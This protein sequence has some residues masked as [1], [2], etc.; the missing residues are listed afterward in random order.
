[1]RIP[2]LLRGLILA[3]SAISP[4]SLLAQFQPLNPDEL[5]MTSDAKAPGA[6]A[7]YLDYEESDNDSLHNQNYYARIKVLTEKGK[8]AATVEL[9]AYR[10]GEFSIGSI[11]GRTIHPDGSI[12]PL[13]VK[14]DELLVVKRGEAQ[15]EKKVFTLPS[16]EVGSVLEYS[17]QL[18][19]NAQFNW[20]LSP[21]WE[22][23]KKYFIRKAHF[24][25]AP[26][27]NL[28]L[29]YWPHLPMG[30]S[31]KTDAGGRYFLDVT[32]VPATPDEEWMPPIDSILYKVMFY[33]R[34]P[35]EPLDAGDYW[36]SEAKE[37]SKEIDQFAEPT[38]TIHEAVDG[39]VTSSDSDLVKAQKLY[40]A[41]EA[42]ENTDYTRRKSESER[43]ELKLKPV[44]RAEDTW[45]Q[46]SGNSN[47]IALLDLAML[48]AAGLTAYATAIVDRDKGLFDPSYMSLSQLDETLVI[49]SVGGKEMLLDPGE[50][51]C[52]FGTVNWRHSG[53]EGLRQSADG[54]GRS[55]TSFQVFGTNTVKRTGDLVVDLH[56]GVTGTLQIVMTGQ[57]A[58]YW[59]Q[60]ALEVDQAELKK[61]FDRSLEE[62][63][64][65][66]VAAHVDHFLGLDEADSLL[67]A[68][69]KVSGTLGTATAKR[70]ILP[71][72]FFETREPEPFVNQATR[73][74]PVDMR[75]ASQIS[76]QLTYDLPQGVTVE[77]A[78]QDAK[79]SWENHAV[80]I[81]KTKPEGEQITIAR[82]LARAFT[83]A[84]P[85]E[86]QDLR[87]FYQKV[88][89]ADQGQLV[90]AVSASP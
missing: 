11:S 68:V 89:A 63:A 34:G 28:S 35:T 3:F 26:T 32:D 49:V 58:L 42:L 84:K 18:R 71:G 1:M 16:V 21:W 23:Q 85:E 36:K 56:G 55:Q 70:I 69:V 60:T 13:N 90:L 87:G 43:H 5:K 57:E 29:V 51:M 7:V 6:D 20:H 77:G 78:P 47:E 4:L 52:P 8:D 75:Y 2:Y 22:V 72:F 66:G 10:R 37:W 15:I 80:Y 39:L 62:M 50:K 45:T 33:Y 83:M 30:S 88:A 24:Q 40:A 74:E 48:R 14:P 61:E 12:V 44:K 54:P 38:K 79:V 19:F 65:Q 31:L 59:R 46:K 17:Y 53:A 86:Y 9:P 81:A 25:F 67:M 27:D 73:L 82:V 41:V 64:P 76:D